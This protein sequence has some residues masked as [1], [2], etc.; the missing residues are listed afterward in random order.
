MA[1]TGW[2]EYK[3]ASDGKCERGRLVFE[4]AAADLCCETRTTTVPY[5]FLPAASLPIRLAIYTG[6][7][8]FAYTSFK[9]LNR[10]HR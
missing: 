2:I 9:V 4:V 10:L 5:P 1:Y 6:G 8:I 3:G 7:T